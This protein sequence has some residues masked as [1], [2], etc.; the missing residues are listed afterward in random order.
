MFMRVVNLLTLKWVFS[1]VRRGRGR[2]GICSVETIRK[3]NGKLL[4]LL[5]LLT[6]MLTFRLL[7]IP[8]V[9]GGC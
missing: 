6:F 2:R 8:N 4:T 5:T 9:Y 7:E 3:L 1:R